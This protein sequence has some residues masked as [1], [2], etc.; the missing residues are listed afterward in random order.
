MRWCGM[1][2]VLVGSWVGISAL[3]AAGGKADTAA[4]EQTL[5]AFGI[6][7]TDQA[8]LEFFRKR[9]LDDD[10]AKIHDYIRDLGDDAYETR[11][12]ASAKLVALGSV[13]EPFLKKALASDDVEVVRRAEDCLRL[14][15]QGVGA[16]LPAAAARLVARRQLAGAAPVLLAY[17]PFAPNTL[18]AEEVRKA[19]TALAVRDGKP[20]PA[21]VAALSDPVA[22]RRAAAA[23][24]LCRSGLTEPRASVKQLLKDPDAEVRLQVALTLANAH[25]RDAIPVLIDLLGQLPR[26]KSW[27]ADEILRRLAGDQAPNVSLGDTEASRHA[28]RQAW[29]DWWQAHGSQVDLAKLSQP[30]PIFGYTIVVLLDTGRILEL[31]RDNKVRWEI[32]G[33]MY[34]LDFQFLPGNRVLVAEN[35]GNRVTERDLKGQVIWEK[36]VE[37]PLMAQRLANGN[38]FIG[39]NS[40]LMEVNP[41]GKEVFAYTP[42]GGEYIM[43]A[44]KLPNGEIACVLSSPRFVRM[45]VTGKEIKSFPVNVRTGGGRIEVLPNGHVLVPE[46]AANR[47]V[48]L[49]EDGKP[50]W[51]AAVQE[52][53]A[54]IR[55]ANG[56]TLV[57][58]MNQHRAIELDAKGKEVWHYQTDTPNGRLNRVNRAYRR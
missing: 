33:L 34:P 48:E 15:R 49:D 44:Q 9:T 41:A 38:T 30:P 45:D 3:S 2:L 1:I 14:I 51:Q 6:D 21:L 4:D 58:S 47:V 26:E 5:K 11:E 42:P 25:D 20:E 18:V 16:S 46:N 32:D 29:A 43:K 55:L 36:Q 19:L 24:A 40:Q 22:G 31:D 56:H 54:A 53:I 28:Y 13:A 27:S 8:L 23:E 57:T 50:V 17:L 37:S 39:T 35:K 10:R 12:R 52:P 7:T